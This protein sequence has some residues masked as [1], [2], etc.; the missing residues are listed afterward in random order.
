[1]TSESNIRRS[2]HEHRSSEGEKKKRGL[3]RKSSAYK[4]IKRGKKFFLAAV[5]V[6][7]FWVMIGIFKF[8]KSPVLQVVINVLLIPMLVILFL[9]PIICLLFLL[10]K[11]FDAKSYYLYALILCFLTIIFVIAFSL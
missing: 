11:K 1:M 7:A 4:D 6:S 10:K 8:Y 3:H 2:S 9:I 5:I